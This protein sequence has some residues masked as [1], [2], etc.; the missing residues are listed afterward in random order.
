MGVIQPAAVQLRER[1][2]KLILACMQH[3]MSILFPAAG[4]KANLEQCSIS[5]GPVPNSTTV[6]VFSSASLMMAGC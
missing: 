6:A 4:Y 1:S 5:E 3:P 2:C